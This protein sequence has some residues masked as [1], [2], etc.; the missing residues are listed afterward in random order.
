MTTDEELI[1]LIDQLR[2]PAGRA[3]RWQYEAD[4]NR[5]KDV[6]HIWDV[7]HPL[8]LAM[9]GHPEF[10]K[11][12]S[13]FFL[14]KQLAFFNS[15]QPVNILNVA[16]RMTGVEALAWYRRVVAT[17]RTRMRVVAQVHGLLVQKR[18]VF[19]NGVILLP[20]SELADSPNSVQLKQPPAMRMGM[21]F[22]AAVMV[23]L[24]DV[25]N[26]ASQVGHGRFLDVSEKM[27]KTIA[28]FVLSDDAAPTM[29]ET[30]QE[31]ADPELVSAEHGRSWMSSRHEGR[32]PTHPVNVTDEM[33]DWVESY[34]SLPPDVAKACEVAIA[35]LNLARRRIAP[36]DKAIDGCVCLEALLSGRSRG[37]LTHRLSVRAAILLGRSL[38]DRKKIAE[39]S[40]KFYAL[41]SDVVH[42]SSGKKDAVNHDIA[43]EGLLLCLA[44]LRSVVTS[45]QV[46]EP[47][48]WELTGGPAW[49]RYVDPKA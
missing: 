4:D 31:F 19:S 37:E 27:R 34:V 25:M 47:E 41:R 39:D 42:G 28:A 7:A 24:P 32:L 18:H 17:D 29:A 5:P 6:Q 15:H 14:G 26:E 22:L 36:G 43:G 20:V 10:G 46:P 8:K 40:R 13:K 35:R 38:D 48:L 30:W 1:T 33:L 12:F 44:V 9:S 21:E 3:F 2:E 45:A 16:Q 11:D 49:N 23:E